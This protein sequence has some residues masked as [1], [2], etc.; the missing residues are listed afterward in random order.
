M[1]NSVVLL[2]KN[3][4]NIN[5]HWNKLLENL[6]F[7]QFTLDKIQDELKFGNKFENI[8]ANFMT[9][10]INNSKSNNQLK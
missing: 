4:Y 8:F 1:V 7:L 10:I 3:L 6:R 9:K 5:R 2:V